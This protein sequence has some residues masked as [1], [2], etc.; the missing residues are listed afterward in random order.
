M[1]YA[2][3][4]NLFSEDSLFKK[5]QMVDAFTFDSNNERAAIVQSKLASS[6]IGTGAIEDLSV[7]T[8]K[9]A[10]SAVTNVKLASSSVDTRVI[11]NRA[12][13]STEIA[14]DSVR[15]THIVN[16]NY[17]VGTGSFGTP[18]FTINAGS[19]ALTTNGDF[20]IETHTGSAILV[21]RHGG[22]SFYFTSA[23]TLA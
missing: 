5:H 23:G 19:P 18:N 9:I 16:Y 11:A 17:G 22:T 4:P 7:T 8:N 21:V 15:G 6:S 13:G 3:D 14:E 10:G 1:S 2:L 12:V 20:A